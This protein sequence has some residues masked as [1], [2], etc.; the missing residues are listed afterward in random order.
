MCIVFGLVQGRVFALP[1]GLQEELCRPHFACG[2]LPHLGVY[3]RLELCICSHCGSSARGEM[4]GLV[5]CKFQKQELVIPVSS[6][7]FNVR[8]CPAL[9]SNTYVP[10]DN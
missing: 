9:S 10:A 3:L 7:V 5:L 4:L 2:H 6:C 8:S 1:K